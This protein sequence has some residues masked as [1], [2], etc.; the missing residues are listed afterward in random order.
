MKAYRTA[1]LIYI[2][3][4][5][6]F[7]LKYGLR[8]VAWPV[9]LPLCIL[10][11]CGVVAV[12]KYMIPRLPHFSCAARLFYIVL[13]IGVL[14]AAQ[15]SLDPMT[16]QVDRWSAI[17][18]FLNHLVH[19]IYPYAAQTHL[20]GY[21]SPFPVWQLL[22]L[23]FYWLGNVGLSFAVGLILFTHSLSLHIG[24]HR[25]CIAL[26]LVALSPA[27][28][29]EVL[30]RSDLMTNFLV[31][32]SLLLY[33]IHY[34]LSINKHTWLLGVIVGLLMSTR[35][36]AVIPF[37]VYYFHEFC[38]LR[39][40]KMA[41]FSGIVLLTFVL[42]F[43]PFLFWDSEMLLFFQFNPFILQTRQGHPID[44][45]LVIGVGIY[46]SFWQRKYPDRHL[47]A[48]AMLLLLLVCITFLHNM[49]L[50]QNW[51][52]LFESAYDITYFGMA[53]PFICCFLS[54]RLPSQLTIHTTP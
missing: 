48:S 30:V 4:G 50:H 17:H 35:F 42:T 54:Y 31:C 38:G 29:Y 44:L 24:W 51:T 26:T 27:F 9:I 28:I 47:L 1:L 43:L 22:H 37:C 25:S 18:N 11:A 40:S 23:P 49:Y 20:G 6:L 21:G 10:Y 8:L 33:S 15:C 13:M 12:C 3:T 39:I 45:L 53:L 14:V 52:S 41:A 34:R 16:I 46:L 36:S 2:L 19:G 7:L 32:L 5:S